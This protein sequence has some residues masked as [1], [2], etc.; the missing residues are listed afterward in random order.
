MFIKNCAQFFLQI[1]QFLVCTL[2]SAKLYHHQ[3]LMYGMLHSEICFS[4]SDQD[5]VTSRELQVV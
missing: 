4:S 3:E 2:Y 5:I 1:V